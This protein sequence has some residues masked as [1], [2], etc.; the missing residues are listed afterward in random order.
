M[1]AAP[2]PLDPSLWHATAAP[3]PD[4]PPL[5]KDVEVDVAIVGGGYAGLSTALHLAERGVGCMVLEAREP[6]WGGSGRNGGQVIPGLKYDPD[7]MVEKFGPEAGKALTAFAASTADT[8]FELIAKHQMNVPHVRNGWIQGAHIPSMIETAKKRSAQW[9]ALGANTEFFDKAKTDEHLGTDVYLAGWIDRRGGAVQPLSYAR[10]LCRAAQRAGAVVHGQTPVAGLSQEGS[11]WKVKTAQGRT[12]TAGKVVLCTNGYTKDYYPKLART[13]IAPNSYQVATEPL[14][15]N[16]RKSILP[17]GQVSS[18][19]RQLLLYFRLDHEGRLLMGGRGPFREPNDKSDWAHLERVIA[20]MFPAAKD[21][22]I[23]Y[24]WCGRVA[25]TRDFLPHLH[26]PEP[27]LIVNIG[28][29]GRG[30][31]LESTMGKALAAYAAT[32]DRKTLPFPVTPVRTI[33]FHG[34]NR[35]YVAAVVTYYRMRDAGLA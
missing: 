21:A 25:V 29:M 24:R 20:R 35:A 3:A 1:S 23:Q 6:G 18:D 8:V 9:A 33:P 34:L 19:T 4:C 11:K 22:P 13:V 7:E 15:D 17:Y 5:D 14:S 32:G 12:V 26:E 27:G 16:V 30:V 2:F 31:G 28:C 10:E